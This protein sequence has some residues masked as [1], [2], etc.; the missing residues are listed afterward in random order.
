ML[1]AN[2]QG[3]LLI[4]LASCACRADERKPHILDFDREP[5]VRAS[6]Q[7]FIAKRVIPGAVYWIEREGETIH[8]SLG[9]RA[10]I[11]KKEAIGADT[12]FD[13][14][15]LTKV[16][17]TTT[18]VM[19]LVE[20]GRVRPEAPVSGYIPEFTGEG[21][22]KITVK[23]LLTHVSGMKPDLPKEPAWSGYETGVR[24]VCETAPDHAPEEQF[25][26]SDLN[27]I[28]LG[29]IV[30]R[31]SGEMLDAFAKKHVF[32]PLKMGDTAF[33]PDGKLRT[34]IAPTERDENGEML[35]GVAHDPTARRMGGVAGHAGLFG[36]A[37][38]LA[39]FC[40]MVMGGGELDGVRLLKP[41]T[42]RLM[43]SVQTPATMLEKRGLGWDIDTRFSRP[44]GA[45]FPIGSFGHTGFT[46]TCVWMDPF[47]KA[48]YVFLSSRLHAT[49]RT[50]DSR[51][52]YDEMGT[53][54]ALC[55]LNFDFTDVP[56][57]LKAT[58]QT[59]K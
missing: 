54:A 56:G 27:F 1:A 53:Q 44:R 59:L 3:A 47:S 39:R 16:V 14:A 28:L 11:P 43:T 58:E 6:L 26:Y 55:V 5:E 7:K 12:I 46:G 17:A 35:R 24:K 20:Q 42:V 52:C 31:V 45:L 40:R 29:E 37:A 41:A 23:H 50:T 25:R 13:L 4:A 38:D 36:T 34:R 21:R 51:Q 10:V 15:S 9:W 48:F 30:H 2:I 19:L 8:G 49:D 22:E 18:S 32:A 57:A 33:H